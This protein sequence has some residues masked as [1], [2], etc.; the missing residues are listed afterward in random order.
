MNKNRI[1]YREELKRFKTVILFCAA[2]MIYSC[3]TGGAPQITITDARLVGK[4]D[5]AAFM[6]ITNRGNGSD[7]L[8]GCSIK[9][10]TAVRVE[11]HDVVDGVMEEI[12]ELNIPANKTTFLK[13]GSFHVMLFGLPETL[14]DAI[15]LLLHFEKSG[16]I[17]VKVPT[18]LIK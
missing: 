12:K 15:T 9:D 16:I 4:G 1:F 5:A 8:I 3:Y 13:P 14:G 11:L 18:K 2:F 7:T 10:Y 17:E 6:F